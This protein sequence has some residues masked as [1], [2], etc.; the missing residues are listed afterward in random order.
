[1]PGDQ[2]DANEFPTGWNS[3]KPFDERD[4]K[5]AIPGTYYVA[6]G[7]TKYPPDP[8]TGTPEQKATA[9]DNFWF[10]TMENNVTDDG[11]KANMVG[12]HQFLHL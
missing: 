3:L 8:D 11:K 9:R 4:T 7:E 5:N 1:M 10:S 12:S 2:G 6:G